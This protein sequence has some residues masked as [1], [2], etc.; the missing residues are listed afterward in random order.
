MTK[1]GLLP[2]IG[3]LSRSLT[4]QLGVL[5]V[6]FLALPVVL[7][8]IF[9]AADA[10]KRDLLLDAVRQNGVLIGQALVPELGGAAPAD[11]GRLPQELERF[12]SDQT[13]V[14]LL[15]KP[16]GQAD[17]GGFF[18]VAGAPAVAPERLAEERDRLQQLGIL[19]QLT[20]TCAGNRPLSERL[21]AGAG[22]GAGEIL[23]SVTPVQSPSGCWVVV[24][25]A[26][27][28]ALGA[29]DD[30]PFWARGPARLAL[31]LYAAMALLT[32]ALVVGIRL[33]LRRIRK[34]AEVADRGVR[35]EAVAPPELAPTARELDRLVERLRGTAD[36]IRQAAED[37]AHALKGPIAV[38]RQ[39]LD[40]L[41]ASA[42]DPARLARAL[43]TAAKC[44]DRLDG[45]VRSARNLDVAAA[46]MLEVTCVPVD[47]SGLVRRYAG[48]QAALLDRRTC[49]LAFDVADGVS[50]SGSAELIET[51]LENLVDNAMSFSPHAGRVLVQV[52]ADSGTATLMVSDEGPGVP[53]EALDRIFDRYYSDRPSQPAGAA[54]FGIGLWLVRQAA[55]AMGGSVHARNRPEG[56]FEVRLQLVRAAAAPAPAKARPTAL[57]TVGAASGRA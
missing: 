42:E 57:A 38:M 24:V 3:R 55:F 39:A 20:Q 50:V 18:F 44:L 27:Q 7:Y 26:D 29:A 31:A 47:L 32:G 21:N 14:K 28:K 34:V 1:T 8:T 40:P 6:I 25:A 36:L 19:D 30:R 54:H 56:G 16:G 23:T 37:N 9:A 11:F 5:V 46:E 33:S 41:I 45:L 17:A 12:R 49:W 52:S 53:P 35:F 43:A 22:D 4:A 51:V 48:D 13:N 2:P 15:F 10:E